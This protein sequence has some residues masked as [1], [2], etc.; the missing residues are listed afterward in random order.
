MISKETKMI[1]VQVIAFLCFLIFCNSLSHAAVTL[2][3]GEGS[4][5]PGSTDNTVAVSLNNPADNVG[6][7]QVDVCDEDDYLTPVLDEGTFSGYK[8]CDTINRA[9][10]FRCSVNELD[11]GCCRVILFSTDPSNSIIEK[12]TGD[13]FTL[14][15]EVSGEAN[16]GECRDLNPEKEVVLD[17]GNH[18]LSVEL[19]SGEFCFPACTS[20]S[21]CE[22]GQY[23]NG[24]DS[25]ASGIC[26]H[27]GDPCPSGTVCDE[28]TNSCITNTTTTIPPTTTTT[29]ITPTTVPIT[30]TTTTGPS[31]QISI[32]PSSATLDS[33]VTLQFSAKTTDNGEEVAGTYIWEIVPESTIGSEIDVGGLFTAGENTTES[34]IEETVRVTDTAH[35][36]K[37]ATATVTIKVKEQPPPECEVRI[38][39]TPATVASGDTLTLI[40]NT[41]GDNCEISDYEWSINSEIGSMVDQEGN[42]TA[43]SNN[44]E[45]Q[46]TDTI[47][48]I[49]HANGDI[50]ATATIKVEI[51]ETHKTVKIFP[52]TLLSSR[53]IPLPCFLLITGEDTN[54]K[55]R[56]T[57]SFNPDNIVPV[58][59]VGSGNIMIALVLL[60]ANPQEGTVTITI[61]T[62]GED[63]MGE[64]TIKLLPF[65]FDENYSSRVE[66]STNISSDNPS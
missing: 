49:D 13:I 22:D 24:D 55:P 37:S 9:S 48:V 51:E 57:I 5:P 30:T 8:D 11:N 31:Y 17:E 7:M 26:V 2:T 18:T 41:I 12:G 27:S 16:K 40:A 14:Y 61:S 66:S 21:D 4:G 1:S 64:I 6:G 58:F 45:S 42:Y 46:A 43:G 53:W 35:E 3:I 52:G 60:K 10:M 39:P 38:N 33:G 56:S 47:T 19:E 32:S 62:G 34:N 15:Y 50:S 63:V 23:C 25:C 44:T 28:D 59:Q 65:I 54:F 20:D 29:P 36:N